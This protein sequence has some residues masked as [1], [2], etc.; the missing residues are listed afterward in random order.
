MDLSAPYRAIL[1]KDEGAVLS[2]LAG[3]NASLT[4]REVARRADSARSTVA[5][6]LGRLAEHGVV[7]ADQ[8]GAAR[9]YSLNREH[10]IAESILALVRLRGHLVERL[11]AELQSW[12]PPARH[13]SLFG[14]AA[15]GDGDTRSDI[16]ILVVR[17][18]DV[19]E[20]H[21]R[22]RQQVD[23]LPARIEDWTGNHASIAE[24][25][26]GDLPRLARERRHVAT[27]LRRDA[28]TLVGPGAR[29]VL[30]KSAA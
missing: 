25:P 30:G 28:I 29:E 19:D 18:D 23:A 4:G 27:E 8:A 13:A 6:I 12:D 15:R 2:A 11:V 21:L 24:V 22:W 5:R 9:L 16:D 20:E 17:P 26:E 10:L 1:S 3:T 14:S 7:R